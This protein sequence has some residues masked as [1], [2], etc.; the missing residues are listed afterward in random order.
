MITKA[1]KFKMYPNK[2][3]MRQIET[4]CNA[5]IKAWNLA[6]EL[7]EAYYALH[8]SDPDEEMEYAHSVLH[9]EGQ[10]ASLSNFD[11]GKMCKVW[12][13][14]VCPW[15]AE[16][17]AH[18]TRSAARDLDDAFKSFFRRVKRG[19]TPGYPKY[20][21]M[22][23]NTKSYRTQNTRSKRG[24]STY[25]SI[26]VIDKTHVL[27][28]KLGSVRCRGD[29]SRV[30]GKIQNATVRRC[31]SGRYEVSLCCIEVPEP[32][33]PMGM[34]DVMGVRVGVADGVTRSD[35]IV[36]EH[37]RALKRAEKKL[38]REQRRLSRKKKGSNN[39]RKQRAKVAKVNER[40]A[41]IRANHSHTLTKQIVRD[42]KAVVVGKPAIQ[43]MTRKRSGKG[44]NVQRK[45]NKALLDVAAYEIARQLEYKSGWYG[46]EF[47][48]LEDGLP[49]TR[50]CSRCGEETGPTVPGV[51][52]WT[53][54][55]CGTTHDT[56]L[57][58]ALN[59]KFEG[60][61]EIEMRK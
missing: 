14:T 44:R 45:Q 16:A 13:D 25:E 54:P 35:G 17:D 46:R 6:L 42:S 28:P 48:K 7:H 4:S 36:I 18:S 9:K 24:G 11:I 15:F 10:K 30:Q 60:A 2:E 41:F 34:V 21:S 32:E 55:N 26:R 56:A 52:T 5:H 20:K 43:Q 22:R 49:W 8:R 27:L 3:Q 33:M 50:T 58:A 47:V 53:C 1:Y 51:K 37:P 29:L 19:E 31:S 12:K 61:A 38:A 59:I 40:V 57:N 23:A 39:Y